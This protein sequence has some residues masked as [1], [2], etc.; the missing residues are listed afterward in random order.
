MIS[1]CAFLRLTR[2]K[3]L[4]SL[5]GSSCLTNGCDSCEA[6]TDDVVE[7]AEVESG[8]LSGMSISSKNVRMDWTVITVSFKPGGKPIP[9]SVKTSFIFLSK[10]GFKR[11]MSG[12]GFIFSFASSM[13]A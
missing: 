2:D 4:N 7:A 11:S 12:R 8:K 3:F 9:L 5:Y 13:I 10:A 6:C 1:V